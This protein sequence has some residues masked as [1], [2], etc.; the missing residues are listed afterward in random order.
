VISWPG[1]P[2]LEIAIVVHACL[3]GHGSSR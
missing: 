3:S 1:I 2:W